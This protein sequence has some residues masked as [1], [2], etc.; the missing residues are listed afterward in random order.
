MAKRVER[1][2]EIPS[3]KRQSTA[4]RWNTR[5]Q[6]SKRSQKASR[7]SPMNK[8]VK[9]SWR[10][11]RDGGFRRQHSSASHERNQSCRALD[12]TMCPI[13]WRSRRSLLGSTDS[14]GDVTIASPQPDAPGAETVPLLI[15]RLPY[16][17]RSPRSNGGRDAALQTLPLPVPTLTQP[18]HRALAAEV[19]GTRYRSEDPLFPSPLSRSSTQDSKP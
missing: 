2:H 17:L 5:L 14:T 6:L 4:V 16:R 12:G 7:Q 19:P 18:E 8:S 9:S 15:S 1:T 11:S 3:A 13:P 10:A